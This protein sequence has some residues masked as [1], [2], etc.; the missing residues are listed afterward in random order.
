M[1]TALE[2][3]RFSEERCLRDRIA[4]VRLAVNDILFAPATEK[5]HI[6][7]IDEGQ[8]ELH[9]LMQ[10]STPDRVER[11]GSGEYFGLGFLTHYAYAAIA[12]ADARIQKL[13]RAAAKSLAETDAKLRQRDAIENQREFA[14][15]RE[16]MIAASSQPLPQRLATFLAVLS[17]FN[18]YEG[19]DPLVVN[20]DVAGLVVADYLATDVTAL[21]QALSQLSDLGAIELAPP[22]GLRIRDIG[23]LEYIADAPEALPP[24]R[25][26]K[27]VKVL[28]LPRHD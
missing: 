16:M 14:H 1:S 15:R 2:V 9:W 5:Q 10:R 28:P 8:I 6:Y 21:G 23:F 20:E 22:H 25:A 26:S 19:R 4:G 18:A 3:S 24:N 7:W 11:L 12:V 13:P 27:A 17:R